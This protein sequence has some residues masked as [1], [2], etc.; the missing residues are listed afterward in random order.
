MK[1][2]LTLSL[3]VISV[4]A[5]AGCNNAQTEAERLRQE[6]EAKLNEANQQAQELQQQ[7]EQMMNDA[8]EKLDQAQNAANAVNELSQ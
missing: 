7:G 5:L 6:A 1:K 4:L 8:Q 3:T 2:I